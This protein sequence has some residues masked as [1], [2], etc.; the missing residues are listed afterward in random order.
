MTRSTAP[1]RLSRDR[2]ERKICSRLLGTQPPTYRCVGNSKGVIETFTRLIELDG[3]HQMLNTIRPIIPNIVIGLIVAPVKCLRI[4]EM[5]N[6][7]VVN[8]DVGPCSLLKLLSHLSFKIRISYS[9]FR[10]TRPQLAAFLITM[11]FCK[12]YWTMKPIMAKIPRM[13]IG[14]VLAQGR[15]QKFG[16]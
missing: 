9:C 14:P 7:R 6:P 12:K 16:K 4:Y 15:I 1:P 10:F 5:N 2:E 3:N 11:G 8:L 13:M